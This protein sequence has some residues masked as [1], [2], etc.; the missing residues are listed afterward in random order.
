MIGGLVNRLFGK[1]EE[2][3]EGDLLGLNK[4]K[5]K[6]EGEKESVVDEFLSAS[7]AVRRE[8]ETPGGKFYN[9]VW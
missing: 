5:E 8:M 6:K 9:E 2:K 3:E 7:E 1:K 4:E